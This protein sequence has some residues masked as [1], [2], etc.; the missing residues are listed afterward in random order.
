MPILLKD[1]VRYEERTPASEDELE[2]VVKEHAQDIFGE[3]SIYFDKK[4]RLKTLAGVGSIPDGLVVIFGGTPQWHIVE[5]EL[6]SH[7]PYAHIVPQ[8][9]KFLNAIDNIGTRNRIIEVLYNAVS[10]DELLQLKTRQA[11][12]HGKD[13][14]KF[15]SDLIAT[16]PTITILIEKITD[17]LREALKKYPQKRVVEVR[18]YRREKAEAVHAHLFEPLYQ[19]PAGI[20]TGRGGAEV[21]TPPKGPVKRVTIKNLI[22]ANILK[23]GQV[24]YRDYKGQIFKGRILD[25]GSIQL[26]HTGVKFA[27]L[28]SAAEPIAGSVDGWSWWHT[29]RADGKECSLDDLRKE[30][31]TNPSP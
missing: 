4:Q 7:D 12:G 25:D 2:E 6:S 15:L 30:Y 23:V 24:I 16:Q 31:R 28:S 19:V 14:H 29:K 22:D 20:P 10:G 3:Q 17:Q 26:V 8:V 1:G 9:D 13:I 5:V 21:V 11:I 18:T 27:S